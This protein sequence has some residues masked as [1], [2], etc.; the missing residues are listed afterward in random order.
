[1]LHTY[2]RL[3]DSYYQKNGAKEVKFLSENYRELI[4][5][6]HVSISFKHNA[7]HANLAIIRPDLISIEASNLQHYYCNM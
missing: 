6:D 1:M 2:D 5:K 3:I 7:F 4:K